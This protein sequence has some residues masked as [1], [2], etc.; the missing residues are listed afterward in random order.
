MDNVEGLRTWIELNTENIKKNYQAFRSLLVPEVKMMAVVKS[1]A[2]GHGLVDF[3]KEIENCGI[4]WLGVDSV[5]EGLTLRKEG[6]KAPIL[7]L[8]FTLP[9]RIEEAVEADVSITVSNMPLLEKIVTLK[10]SKK[11]KIHVKA[12]TGLHRQGF[13]ESEMKNVIDFLAAHAD[14]FHVEGLYTHFAKA[15]DPADKSYTLEQL[16][17]F[18]AWRDGFRQAGFTP[19]V[20]AAATGGALIYPEAHFDMV[21]IGAGFYGIWP[22]KETRQ[23]FESKFK[24]HPVLSW[25]TIVVETKYFPKGVG[26]G[27]DLT[28]TLGRDSTIAICPIGYWHGFPRSLS[29]IGEVIVNGKKAKVI[30]RVSMDMIVIDITDILEAKIGVQVTLVGMGKGEKIAADDLAGKAGVS[31]YEFLTRINPLIYKKHI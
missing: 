4:D 23:A 14:I 16:A 5:V 1:N 25:K 9:E 26:I 30:G 7:V 24:L 21:R 11:V 2:Y 28:E 10:L 13:E 15:K 20:H 27:Y 8:G 19:I 22:S 31:T 6:I 12:D 17:V 3:S 18:N 29:S